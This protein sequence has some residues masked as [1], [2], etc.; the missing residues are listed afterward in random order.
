MIIQQLTTGIKEDIEMSANQITKNI[1]PEFCFFEEPF[2]CYY[3]KKE[4]ISATKVNFSINNRL[5]KLI[6]TILLTLSILHKNGLSHQSINLKSIF[7][8]PKEECFFMGEYSSVIKIEGT[9]N[10]NSPKKISSFLDDLL[11]LE[12]TINKIVRI[13]KSASID[14]HYLNVF[15][16]IKQE[17]NIKRIKDANDVL[18]ILK[19]EKNHKIPSLPLI[20]IEMED[21]FKPFLHIKYY[22]EKYDNMNLNF[23]NTTQDSIDFSAILDKKKEL[24]LEQ[25]L[26]LSHSLKKNSSLIALNLTNNDISDQE[27]KI[28][29]DCLKINT[30]LKSFNLSNNKIDDNGIKHICDALKWNSSLNR[31]DISFNDVNQK[32]IEYL[33]NTL[34]F[35]HSLT[36]V[37][38]KKGT[39]ETELQQKIE[40]LLNKNKIIDSFAKFQRKSK[41]MLSQ[42]DN[43]D[44]YEYEE[45]II[46][47]IFISEIPENL[48]CTICKNLMKNVQN[49]TKCFSNFCEKCCEE[50]KYCPLG[51]CE[52]V[53]MKPNELFSNEISKIKTKCSICQQEIAYGSFKEH[54]KQH[55]EVIHCKA[56]AIKEGEKGCDYVGFIEEV[57]LHQMYC[58]FVEEMKAK[59]IDKIYDSLHQLNKNVKY[60]NEILQEIISKTSPKN[61]ILQGEI[62]ERILIEEN[63]DLL[64]LLN[65]SHHF[66][67]LKGI[68]KKKEQVKLNQISFFIKNNCS[69][70]N[71]DLS[72][73]N[74]DDNGIKHICDALKWN[75][76]LNR[77]DISFND[78]NQKGIEYLYNTLHFNHSL[79]SVS[80]KKGT[81]ETELQQ[82]IELL[83]NKN[84]II[85]S[86]AKFQR[87]SKLMLSQFDNLDNY[88]YEEPI[89]KP[90]FISEIPENL[91]CT[92]CKNLM[93]NV[94]NC[95]KCFSNFCEKCCEEKKYCPL[96]K[97]EKV[98]MK[99]NELF[100]NEISK[101]KTKCSICQQEIAYGSFK[102]HSKQHR[103]VIHCKAKAIKEGEKGCDYVGFIEEV[104]LHQMYCKFV[105]EMNTKE[106]K[107]IFEKLLNLN[108]KLLQK[109]KIQL[110]VVIEENKKN[111][112]ENPH[113]IHLEN[114]LSQTLPI[115]SALSKKSNNNSSTNSFLSIKFS[116]LSNTDYN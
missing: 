111:F 73:N 81:I 21:Y 83:L 3:I 90:I 89:I 1:F 67:D 11:R 53:L 20:V 30:T 43:L 33:Y 36:S 78:V 68:L 5:N 44:N 45:P 13:Y 55:R 77:I 87:K 72:N 39:I 100:S 98:L 12:N 25:I 71:I 19:N 35:N 96:G 101:I 29:S 40:L 62:N 95:T 112:F 51:K 23:L 65:S 93:K 60:D 114:H 26:L 94:Q 66:V 116:G 86:F 88:E 92:I 75:S 34:H 18:D 115:S 74:I 102:E 46:K 85:D 48:K 10:E 16:I 76:S 61:E 106:K 41:L 103:E 14:N 56:K 97:C 24:L 105:E 59:E 6:L 50:K 27:I 109:N 57:N 15:E 108:K 42:F 52:K 8:Y 84:K 79:T 32:G 2:L 47:P 64:E 99:P 110:N 9:K 38:Y 54:S 49:C 113:K 37:S 4:V 107:I 17:N 82:K 69:L 80:Y 7:F 63:G 104:N 70:K 22:N 28:L 31:I 58:K 91:K